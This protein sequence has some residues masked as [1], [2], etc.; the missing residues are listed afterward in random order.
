M[1]AK[2]APRWRYDGQLVA[3]EGQLG[4]QGGQLGSILGAVLAHLRHLGANFIENVQNAKYG[5]LNQLSEKYIDISVV[6]AATA[7]ALWLHSFAGLSE[8]SVSSLICC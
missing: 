8:L 2:L 6:S 5:N 3:Q 1:E 4:A 7:F